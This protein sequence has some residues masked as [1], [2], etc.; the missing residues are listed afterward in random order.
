MFHRGAV[1]WLEVGEGRQ[2]HRVK[3]Y[4][5]KLGYSTYQCKLGHRDY[6]IRSSNNFTRKVEKT[7]GKKS[8]STLEAM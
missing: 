4:R 8:C 2:F 5:K 3:F 1:W 6:L 7:V